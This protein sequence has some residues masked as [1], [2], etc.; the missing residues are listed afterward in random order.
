[1][2][3]LHLCMHGWHEALVSV[4]INLPRTPYIP[5][6]VSKRKRSATSASLAD[7]P[8]EKRTIDECIKFKMDLER[9]DALSIKGEH[10]PG[11][12]IRLLYANA[13]RRLVNLLKPHLDAVKDTAYTH[14]ELGLCGKIKKVKPCDIQSAESISDLLRRI[15]IDAN[16]ESICFLQQAVDVIPAKTIEREEAQAILSHY[17]NHLNIYEGATELAKRKKPERVG[18]GKATK[19]VV[20]VEI[21]SSKSYT[22]FTC[23]DCRRLQIHILSQAYDIPEEQIICFDEEERNSTTVIFLIPDKY[24]RVIMQRSSQ[25]RTVWILLE[26]HV[27]EVTIPG[28]FTFIPSVQFFLSLLREDKTFTADLLSVTEVRVLYTI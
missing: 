7:T 23:R 13:Y 5:L 19:Q 10:D 27:I 20:P 16:W 8:A 22:K 14:I 28:V 26:L 6:E 11:R 2:S 18:K 3:M 17:N 4:V 25:L 9:Q 12:A 24:I 21:T 1:M 15:S